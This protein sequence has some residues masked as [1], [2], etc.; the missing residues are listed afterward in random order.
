MTV[1]YQVSFVPV[2]WTYREEQTIAANSI[3]YFGI[4]LDGNV[5]MATTQN[6]NCAKMICLSLELASSYI[7]GDGAATRELLAQLSKLRN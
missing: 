2:K 6:E 4:Y 1:T 5:M 7:W 3:R